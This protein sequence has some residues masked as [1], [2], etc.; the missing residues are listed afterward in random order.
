MFGAGVSVVQ[1]AVG[2]DFVGGLALGDF[3]LVE[4]FLRSDAGKKPLLLVKDLL[5][6][7]VVPQ[8]NARR[9]F[10]KQFSSAVGNNDFRIA[11]VFYA[12]AQNARI[13]DNA[14]GF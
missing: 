7:D 4:Y 6:G 1:K 5:R 2:K 8:Q 10:H 12:R 9:N 11:D 3:Y 14:E 13:A